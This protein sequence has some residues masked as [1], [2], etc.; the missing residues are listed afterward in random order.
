M[1]EI[2]IDGISVNLLPEQTILEAAHKAGI[3]I[4]TLCH[5]PA[6]TSHAGCRLCMVEI[7][8]PTGVQLVTACNYPVRRDMVVS[9]KSERAVRA[10]RGVMQLMLAKSPD[11]KQL[12]DIAARM[13]V[14]DTPYEKATES[15]GNCIL[16][17]LCIRVCEEAI[18][19]SAIGYAGRGTE[20]IVT[21]P[22]GMNAEQCIVCGAC[23]AVC[24]VGTI[25]IRIDE[26]AGEA[27]LE[28][29]HA[30]VR[31]AVCEECGKRTVSEPVRKVVFGKL[32]F[33]WRKFKELSKLCPHCR[34]KRAAETLRISA[35]VPIP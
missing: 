26:K 35:T 9:T 31:L 27:E 21:A 2:V 34:R 5:H 14:Y 8:S 12:I 16:C 11:C 6:V 7:V 10:R 25:S 15:R 20:K 13:G 23:A 17:G 29:F 4:P 22:F 32:E 28:P 19:C 30:K 18:G 1:P 33:D 3:W 24:P